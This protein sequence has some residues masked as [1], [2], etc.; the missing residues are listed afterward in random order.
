MPT[1]LPFF[2]MLGYLIVPI[3][4]DFSAFWYLHAVMPF[5][6]FYKLLQGAV[7]EFLHSKALCL[8]DQLPNKSPCGN[9]HLQKQKIIPID[10]TSKL[11]E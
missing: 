7:I 1:V 8:F 10:F 3:T 11:I 9:E 4:S 5:M 2:F 6:S